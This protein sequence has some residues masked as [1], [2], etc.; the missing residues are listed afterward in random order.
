MKTWHLA[1]ELNKCQLDLQENVGC[2]S[3]ICILHAHSHHFSSAIPEL[4]ISGSQLVF[5]NSKKKKMRNAIMYIVAMAFRLINKLM[6][7]TAQKSRLWPS[8]Q[9]SLIN[10][11]KITYFENKSCILFL[12]MTPFSRLPL[13]ACAFP[14]RCDGW[15]CWIIIFPP[16]GE[17]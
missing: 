5:T 13:G 7:I 15:K 9:L 4:D 3:P 6:V 8:C 14:R 12:K 17:E 10:Y 11:H 2:S 1:P 16:I